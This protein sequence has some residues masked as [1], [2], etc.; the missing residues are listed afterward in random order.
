MT[1]AALFR[2]QPFLQGERI[3]PKP[4]WLSA[5]EARLAGA[6][7]LHPN[8]LSALKLA[9]IVPLALALPQV[10]LIPGTAAV[11]LPVLCLFFALDY[12]DGV[13]ARERDQCTTFGR[14]FDRITDYP[15][16]FLLAFQC[17]DALP[18]LLVG[19][20]LCLDLVLLGLF[21]AGRGPVENRVRT[22]L[23]CAILSVLLAGAL[24]WAPAALASRAAATLLWV[25]IG[26]CVAII[27][28]RSGAFAPRR[29]ADMLSGG[30]L[31]CGLASVAFALQGRFDLCLPL[32]LLGAALDGLDGAAARRWGGSRFGVYSDDIADAVSYGVAPGV[33]LACALGG[34]AGAV[35]G[36]VFALFT[37]TR[38]VY[39]TLNKT[40]ADPGTFS[41][42]PS[43]AGAVM[44]LCAVLTVGQHPALVGLLA[45]AAAML[46][47]AFDSRY[48]HL[49]RVVAATPALLLG[50]VPLLGLGITT[51]MLLGP[52]WVAA[53]LLMAAL[54]YGL[55]PMVRHMA[56][57]MG[58]GETKN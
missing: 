41:G 7:S 51:W 10:G 15:L 58:V 21:I 16:L 56:A 24:G 17:Q 49:G 57:V 55:W 31:V 48:R 40:T 13:V 32:L 28:V 44:A 34:L 50:M 26:L 46:M 52:Q 30:N 35:V 53:P 38:L 1:A 18:Y 6:F 8:Y 14:V 54:G 25:N 23:S 47:V 37:V 45:G 29:V 2:E 42:L 12:L 9:L 33:A 22:T 11:V 39:F 43:T 36:L 3:I 5:A 27:A 4:G 20:K 19:V